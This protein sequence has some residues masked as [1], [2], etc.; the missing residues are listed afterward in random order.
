MLFLFLAGLTRSLSDRLAHA[1][2]P[3]LD[4]MAKPDG[5]WEV[6]MAKRQAQFNKIL[7]SGVLFAVTSF[8]YVYSAGYFKGLND[9]RIG[10][11][12]TS[13]FFLTEE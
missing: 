6:G 4:G 7:V 8:G 1:K 9:P 3:T 2:I 5:P 12:G 10:K 13:D 11:S